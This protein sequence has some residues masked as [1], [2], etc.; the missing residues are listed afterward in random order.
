MFSRNMN[1]SKLVSYCEPLHVLILHECMLSLR[2]NVKIYDNDSNN[3]VLKFIL[4][5]HKYATY[6]YAV[7][8]A[9]FRSQTFEAASWCRAAESQPGARGK[10]VSWAPSL[11]CLYMHATKMFSPSL[12]L[13]LAWCH[14]VQSKLIENIRN[15]CNAFITRRHYRQQPCALFC[16]RI[17][18]LRRRSL[19]AS[20]ALTPQPMFPM[21]IWH[22]VDRR[23]FL[24]R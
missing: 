12:G 24:E 15:D 8:P 1:F 17:I 6:T 18:Q 11:I 22:I 23:F 20:P 9:N 3:K 14:V 16:L 19:P 10:N 5:T 13:Q 7:L 4:Y 2:N 21:S